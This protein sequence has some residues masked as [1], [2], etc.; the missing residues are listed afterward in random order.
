MNVSS[1]GETATKTG[2]HAT[3]VERASERELVI[4]RVFRARPA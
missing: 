3:E 2:K 1:G 4:C